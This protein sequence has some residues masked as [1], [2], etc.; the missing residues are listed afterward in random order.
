MKIK[1]TENIFV[2]G[3]YLA[4]IGAIAAAILAVVYKKTEPIILKAEAKTAQE[5]VAKIVPE[6]NNNPI[7]EKTI[8]ISAVNQAKKIEFYPIKK[9][10][11][12]ISIVAF[13]KEKGYGPEIEVLTSF[14][15]PSLTIDKIIIQK[16]NETPGIGS[17]VVKREVQKNSSDIG[18]ETTKI[19]LPPNIFLDDKIWTDLSKKGNSWNAKGEWK[20]KKDGGQ[21]SEI[22]GATVSSRAVTKAVYA[23]IATLKSKQQI[24]L[25]Q[26]NK[27]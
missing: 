25:K 9:D 4:M 16:E 23:S 13:S 20:V 27:Q 19:K 24:I 26:F 10:G 22:T 17:K 5:K 1:D 15:Y 2:L 18:K 11:K 6:F 3:V 7:A 8:E 12:L 21:I 14:N